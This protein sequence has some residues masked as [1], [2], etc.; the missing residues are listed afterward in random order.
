M[1]LELLKHEVLKPAYIVCN[2]CKKLN[3]K[4]CEV[5]K[6]IPPKEIMGG[7]LFKEKDNKEICKYFEQK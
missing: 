3:N 1:S 7:N 6:T 5:Y 4:I 2:E